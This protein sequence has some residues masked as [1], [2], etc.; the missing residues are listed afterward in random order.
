MRRAIFFVPLGFL[1]LF[2]GAVGWRLTNPPDTRIVS[3]LVGRPLPA[4]M[5]PP[6]LPGRDGVS[7]RADGPRLV[8]FFASWCVPC[9]GEAPLLGRLKDEGVAIDGIAVRDR[10]E[11]IARFL[12]RNGDPYRAIGADGDSRAQMLLGSSGVPETYVV[13]RRGI[14]RLHHVGPVE[15]ADLPELRSVLAAAR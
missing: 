7:A 14:I 9:I 3:H 8:N 10:P 11:D 2:L 6:A 4:F 1:L 12:A 13:D 15:A 5:L